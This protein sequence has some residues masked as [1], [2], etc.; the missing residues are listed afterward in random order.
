M[1]L[2][3]PFRRV[4]CFFLGLGRQP[5]HAGHIYPT[6]KERLKSKIHGCYSN[7]RRYHRSVLGVEGRKVQPYMSHLLSRKLRIG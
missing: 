7:L 2:D 4:C 6:P 5:F 1:D 3:L